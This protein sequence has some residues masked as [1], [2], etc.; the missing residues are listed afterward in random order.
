MHVLKRERTP[1]V[2]NL[3]AACFG[4]VLGWFTYFTLRYKT[5]HAM[6]DLSAVIAALGGGAILRLF[7]AGSQVFSYYSIGLAVGF[8]G[9]VAVLLIIGAFSKSLTF[10]DLV[11]PTKA[12][13]PFMMEK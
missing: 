9:Y 2:E 4:A 3:G 1:K 13:N 6:S 12:K 11:D 7:S 10:A 8:F 5:G